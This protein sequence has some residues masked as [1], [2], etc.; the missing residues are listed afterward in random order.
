MPSNYLQIVPIHKYS[1]DDLRIII[2]GTSLFAEIVSS[3]QV[4]LINETGSIHATCT[5]AK[6]VQ[7]SGELQLSIRTIYG[8]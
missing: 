1:V 2:V 3:F 7:N 8:N 4:A 6:S 5:I